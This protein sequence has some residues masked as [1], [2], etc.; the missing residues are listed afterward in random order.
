M[1]FRS[2]LSLSMVLLLMPCCHVYR[3]GNTTCYREVCER[4]TC[5]TSALACTPCGTQSCTQTTLPSEALTEVEEIIEEEE[6][7]DPD[8]VDIDEEPLEIS[9]KIPLDKV[10]SDEKPQ[11]TSKQI[12]LDK[13]SLDDEPLEVE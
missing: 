8:L 5:C 12:V 6:M 7:N 3:K 11:R 4:R 9:P 13:E 1:K 2:L 10:I